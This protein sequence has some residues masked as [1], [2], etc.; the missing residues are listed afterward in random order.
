MGCSTSR[1]LRDDSSLT[2]RPPMSE[3]NGVQGAMFVR[4]VL[5]EDVHEMYDFTGP[6]L[7][8]GAFATVL[9]VRDHMS[10]VEYAV[11][12]IDLSGI[13]D[14]PSTMRM[15]YNEIKGM[16]A[17]NH[18]NIVRLQEVYQPKDEDMM[19]LVLDR[20]SGGSVEALRR[21]KGH[22]EENFAAYI[23][24]Q[25]VDAVRY[26]H[27]L[28][29]VHRDLKLANCMFEDE[30]ASPIVKIIDFGLCKELKNGETSSAFVG[31]MT[32]ASPE[33]VMK[34][35]RHGIECDVWS[36][37][38][39]AYALV[40]GRLPFNAEDPAA[41]QHQI[42]YS[43]QSYADET[44][45]GVSALCRDFI[46]KC[47][48]KLPKKRMTAK[49]AQLHPW[50]RKAAKQMEGAPLSKD[51]MLALV[52]FQK[53]NLFEKVALE[54][55]AYSYE[56]SQIKD[57]ELRFREMD[58]TGKGFVTLADFKAAVMELRLSIAQKESGVAA[59]ARPGEKPA[60][61]EPTNP[62][63]VAPSN[64]RPVGGGTDSREDAEETRTAVAPAPPPPP[65][66]VTA[67]NEERPGAAGAEE[68]TT[69]EETVVGDTEVTG[70]SGTSGEGA[71]AIA[72]ASEDNGERG[73]GPTAEGK[74]KPTAV[75]EE[76]QR[77]G[78]RGAGFGA[79]AESEARAHQQ[80]RR[81]TTTSSVSMEEVGALVSDLNG[82]GSS[83][84]HP[85]DPSERRLYRTQSSRSRTIGGLDEEGVE[86]IFEAMDVDKSG[87]ISI[88]EFVAAS[89]AKQQINTRAI[90]AAFRR[91]D[92]GRTGLITAAD[93]SMYLGET[94]DESKMQQYMREVS[95]REDGLVNLEDFSKCL[96]AHVLKKEGSSSR[97][98]SRRVTNE[99]ID[100]PKIN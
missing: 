29:I 2:I 46:D 48:H 100:R 59:A 18:P 5:D 57:L 41:L 96:K 97:G 4:E 88:T 71:A 33:M 26:C 24:A 92:Y 28:N 30:S 20:L 84:D 39:M 3:D 76:E 89:L 80:E 34:N 37:G 14:D 10:G 6:V 40:G 68:G 17:L 74:Q 65:A 99:S 31:T 82:K 25:V 64:G 75:A 9:R 42:K 79:G 91:L 62:E 87:E 70:D 8:S 51:S 63:V 22:L 52:N 77:G 13:K 86:R 43:Q 72:T 54:L 73:D 15:L 67:P 12:Q 98:S 81:S 11:K 85:V 35:K 44:W 21:Q 27:S 69:R 7:G 93:M 95:S 38:V 16:K 23:V 1:V 66:A 58:K 53:T 32:Y 94:F 49:Q 36:V 45:K 83:A 61:G 50:I 78:G 47:L 56:P 60:G 55:V 19:Y 90:K